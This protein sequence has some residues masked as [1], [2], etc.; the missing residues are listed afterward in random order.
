LLCDGTFSVE[1]RLLLEHSEE[2]LAKS[3]ASVATF[4]QG[5]SFQ[6]DKKIEM[7]TVHRIFDDFRHSY[8][9]EH[10]KLKAC[11]SELLSAYGLLRQWVVVELAGEASMAREVDSFND[12]CEIIDVI[13]FTKRGK[14]TM[15]S[16]SRLLQ[17]AAERHLGKHTLVYGTEHI[18]PKHHWPFDIAEQW[19]EHDLV[20]DA[21]L[22][23]KEHLAAKSFADRACNTR[24]FEQTVLA[25]VLN[26]HV[27]SLQ[28]LGPQRELMGQSVPFPGFPDSLVADNLSIDG[29]VTSVGDFVFLG[30]S[31][32]MVAA[33]ISEGDDFFF[34][35]D[36]LALVARIADHSGN[37]AFND[38]RLVWNAHE[39]RVALA[40]REIAPSVFT[41]IFF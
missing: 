23:E 18:K 31:V 20:V 1:V 39:A 38:Q 35:V 29:V 40:W 2:K 28:K 3:W 25:G 15:E 11:A 14:V 7:R 5:W 16:G 6:R 32:G 36:A 13:L 8:A 19:L 27:E 12:C 26:S 22:I 21:F 33:C 17:Q 4:M 34:V 10:E 30:A 24:I 9:E 37:Y 41:V